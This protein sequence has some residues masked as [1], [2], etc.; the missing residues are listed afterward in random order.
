M[1]LRSR[2]LLLFAVPVALAQ[3][4]LPPADTHSPFRPVAPAPEAT[5]DVLRFGAELPQFEAKDITGRTWRSGDLRGKFTVFYL[6]STAWARITDAVPGYA[7][8]SISD[9]LDLPEVQRFFD[10]I[11]NEHNLQVLTFCK[12]YDSGD[13]MHAADYMKAKKFDFPVIT[14]WAVMGRLFFDRGSSR[15]WLVN[16]QGRLSNPIRVWSFGRLLFEAEKAARN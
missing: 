6:W 1:L 10:K 7:H 5:S 9:V 8:G 13:F 12:D 11:K 3:Q 15:Q 14:D 2:L 16:P 4:A